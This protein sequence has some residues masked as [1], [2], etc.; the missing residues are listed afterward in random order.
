[1][2]RIG[3]DTKLTFTKQYPDFMYLNVC[4]MGGRRSNNLRF[5]TTQLTFTCSKSTIETQE[6][7]VEYV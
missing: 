2:P 4:E 5:G 1:M 7:G 3:S 6:K